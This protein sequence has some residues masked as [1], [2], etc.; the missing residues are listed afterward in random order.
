WVLRIV[1][2]RYRVFRDIRLYRYDTYIHT[3]PP[4]LLPLDS[5]NKCH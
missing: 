1:D 2:D 4:A 5:T 3:S